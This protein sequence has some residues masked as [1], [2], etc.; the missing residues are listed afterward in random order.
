MPVYPPA[1]AAADARTVVTLR[2]TLDELGRVAEVREIGALRAGVAGGRAGFRVT[3]GAGGAAGVAGGGVSGGVVG[4]VAR[5]GVTGGVAGGIAGGASREAEAAMITSAIEAVRRWQYD[6]PAKG[7]MAF[8]VAFAFAPGSDPQ[9]VAYGVAPP[10][11]PPPPPPVPP[12]PPS[13]VPLASPPPAPPPP[14]PPPSPGQPIRVGSGISPPVKT[15]HVDPLYPPLAQS[16]RVQGVVIIEAVIGADGRVQEARIL[17][18]IPLL[19]QAALDAV[20]QWEFQPTL[21][22]GAPVPIIMTMTVQFTLT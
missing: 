22:N 7:P 3:P 21:L 17:R 1:A 18:S 14:P 8:D 16:A 19:D 12:A 4:G 11:P 13:A 6:P 5:G 15:R 2:I 20:R 10:P 9:V